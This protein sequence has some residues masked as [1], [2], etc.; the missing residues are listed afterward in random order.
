MD[1]NKFFV[2]LLTSVFSLFYAWGSNND[3]LNKSLSKYDYFDCVVNGMIK[4]YKNG[5]FGFVNLKG[6]EVVP[7]CAEYIDMGDITNYHSTFCPILVDD[8]ITLFSKKG[9]V[10]KSPQVHSSD[11]AGLIYFKNRIGIV[12]KDKIRYLDSNWY[13][14]RPSDAYILLKCDDGRKEYSLLYDYSGKQILKYD[15]ICYMHSLS[16][17]SSKD[18]FIVKRGGKY[19]VVDINGSIL[20]PYKLD[21]CDID[22]VG[23]YVVCSSAPDVYTLL[24]LQCDTLSSK[25]YDNY[26]EYKDYFFGWKDSECD[27]VYNNKFVDDFIFGGNK[28][29]ANP[30]T[31][32]IISLG[33]ERTVEYFCI[34]QNL[35]M[36]KANGNYGILNKLGQEVI[37]CKY[38]HIDILNN[39]IIAYDTFDL[40]KSLVSIFD[41]EG[42]CIKEHLYYCLF[43]NKSKFHYIFNS[44][45]DENISFIWDDR[46]ANLIEMENIIF[47]RCD[48]G[49]YKQKV[50]NGYKIIKLK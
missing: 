46:K 34:S 9:K 8:T 48:T 49:F 31:T 18:Y 50:G 47:S 15:D 16:F 7:L 1:I 3:R 27:I 19:G 41:K 44:V 36:Y 22:L 25:E 40:N 23:K 13:D 5:K 30:Y 12:V 28:V 39:L 37:P 33:T 32:S 43:D 35:L 6:K 11:Y 4:V 29:I 38:C 20:V 21:Q 45:Y 24:S 42:V 17:N 2:F 14:V 26:F 10:I